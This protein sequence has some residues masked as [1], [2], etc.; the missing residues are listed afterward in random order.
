LKKGEYK[1]ASSDVEQILAHRKLR[2]L[3]GSAVALL[4]YASSIL[5]CA[6]EGNRYE[7]LVQAEE[8]LRVALSLE[9][10]SVGINELLATVLAE[11]GKIDEAIAAFETVLILQPG[12]NYA[13]FKLD[14]LLS[15]KV[16]YVTILSETVAYELALTFLLFKVQILGAKRPVEEEDS[17]EKL[18][19]KAPGL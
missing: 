8:T 2:A 4:Q 5:L 19:Q 1:P 15:D 18:G 10:D 17:V 9:P 14:N 13:K 6:V 11:A 7:A 3:D 12:H 16:F